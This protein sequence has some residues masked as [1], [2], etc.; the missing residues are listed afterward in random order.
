M[1]ETS[2][3]AHTHIQKSYSCTY[4][5]THTWCYARDIFYCTYTHTSCYA[6]D[7]FSC[8]LTHTHTSFYARDIFSCTYTH[9]SCTYFLGRYIYTSF[10]ALTHVLDA[11]LE[12]A[13]LAHTY[14][15]PAHTHGWKKSCL[16]A[17]KKLCPVKPN[18]MLQWVFEIP[19]IFKVQL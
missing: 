9:T 18:G 16:C 3:L 1:L 7:I 14:I 5:H 17:L 15:L 4:T 12:T 2:F 13:F 6:R 10:L 11:T 19:G 8:T